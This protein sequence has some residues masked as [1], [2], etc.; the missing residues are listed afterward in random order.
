MKNDIISDLILWINLEGRELHPAFIAHGQKIYNKLQ[1]IDKKNQT[2]GK[3]D[4]QAK[5]RNVG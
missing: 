3:Y 1:T 2:K 4:R 5:T